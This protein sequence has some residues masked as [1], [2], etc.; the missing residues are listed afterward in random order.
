MSRILR[1]KPDM[2]IFDSLDTDERMILPLK[3]EGLTV[4]SF[5]DLGSGSV[6]TTL[7]I[8]EL[9]DSPEL[10]GAN[11]RWGKDF[12]F[13]RDEFM[14]VCPRAKPQKV[15]NLLLTF[16]GVDQHDL[17]QKIFLQI[18]EL[19]RTSNIEVHVVTGPGYRGEEALRQLVKKSDRVDLT[20]ATGV[21]SRIMAHADLAISSNG[22]T[23]YELAHMNVPG[24]VIDQ[25]AREGTHHFACPENGFINLGL[26]NPGETERAVSCALS[27]LIEDV[28]KHGELYDKTTHHK[29][30]KAGNRGILEI[31]GLLS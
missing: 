13:V 27:A 16:G 17:S 5:E 28:G 26:Y 15:E 4:V 18:R 25:H 31:K 24:I 30:T 14:A 9:F 6:H 22:R 23:V 21:I 19:C 1:C 10:P 8:N 29:F 20:H 12:F 3:K 7:T 11:Y 2:V